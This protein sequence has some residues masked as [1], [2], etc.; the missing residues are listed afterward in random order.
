MRVAELVGSE[1][2]YELNELFAFRAQGLDA[3]GRMTGSFATIN[4]SICESKFEEY[5]LSLTEP[6]AQLSI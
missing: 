6:N 1:N 5:G 3:N 4:Q 2:G